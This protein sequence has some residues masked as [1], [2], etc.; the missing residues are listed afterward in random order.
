MEV[1]E[2]VVKKSSRVFSGF[3]VDDGLKYIKK[4]ILVWR[5]E[6]KMKMLV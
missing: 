4:Y 5:G 6:N 1:C 3:C 2:N